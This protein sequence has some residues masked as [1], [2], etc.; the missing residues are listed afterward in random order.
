MRRC[1]LES[2]GIFMRFIEGEHRNQ[3]TLF[4]VVL[5]DLIP[6]DLGLSLQ[7]QTTLRIRNVV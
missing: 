5:G 7:N 6:D 1:P 3:G 4:P 2:E